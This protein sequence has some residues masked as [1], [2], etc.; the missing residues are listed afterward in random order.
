MKADKRKDETNVLDRLLDRIE[1]WARGNEIEALPAAERER[2]AQDI[3]LNRRE[4]ERLA[5]TEPDAS[6]LLYA[7]LAELG[8]TMEE[9]EATGAG[10]RRD[11]ERTCALCGDRAICAHDLTERPDSQ[12]WRRFCPNN[13]VFTTVESQRESASS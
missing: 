7:R 6:R 3:G 8:L 1:T 10:A 13:P 4:L 5:E 9:V 2:I 11:M 12:E